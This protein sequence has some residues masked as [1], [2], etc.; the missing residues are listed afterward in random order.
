MC[1]WTPGWRAKPTVTAKLCGTRFT[2]TVKV[3]AAA[4]DDDDD[5]DDDDDAGRV[6]KLVQALPRH[7]QEGS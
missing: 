1:G 7:L 6:Q 3:G 2:V 5:D 4:G